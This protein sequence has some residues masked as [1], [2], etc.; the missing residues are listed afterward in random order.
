MKKMFSMIMVVALLV[1]SCAF[2]M[3]EEASWYELSAEGTV[4]TVRLPGNSKNG[5]NWSFEISNP[6]ALELITQE[7]IEGESEGMAGAETTFV[8]S[9]MSTAGVENNVSLIL[10]YNDGSAEADVKTNVLE[11]AVDAENVITVNSVLEQDKNTDLMELGDDG[12]ILTVTVPET[13]P[14]GCTWEQDGGTAL[15]LITFETENGFVGSYMATMENAGSNEL[16]V[17]CVNSDGVAVKTYTFNV[18]INE[19]GEMTPEWV[20]IFEVFA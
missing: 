13:A 4:L 17:S 15:E 12:Y 2:A 20:Q 18:F 8:A 7:V 11:L 19:S 16:N 5:L 14:D 6:E 1:C 3:A 10:H 9:F